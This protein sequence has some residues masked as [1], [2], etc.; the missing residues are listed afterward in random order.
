LA[1]GDVFVGVGDEDGSTFGNSG[2]DL[3]HLGVP[4]ML[5]EVILIEMRSHHSR[6]AQLSLSPLAVPYHR[7]LILCRNERDVVTIAVPFVHAALCGMFR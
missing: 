7:Q 3:L 5:L 1:G 2:P 6:Q 4:L